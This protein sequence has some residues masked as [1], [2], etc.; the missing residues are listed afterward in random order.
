MKIFNTEQFITQ[1][2][3]ERTESLF[4]KD[5][6]NTAEK[7]IDF[8]ENIAPQIVQTLYEMD[9]QSVIIE[10]GLQTLQTFIDADFWDE[11]RIFTGK[12]NLDKGIQAP[13]LPKTNSEKHLIDKDELTILRNHD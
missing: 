3:T 5:I 7:I 4:A 1:H 12:I 13:L 6:E 10:G 8:K 9:I 11:A 2:I